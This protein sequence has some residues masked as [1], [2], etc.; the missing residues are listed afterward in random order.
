ERD[1]AVDAAERNTA[2]QLLN[3]IQHRRAS[4]GRN[5]RIFWPPRRILCPV[6]TQSFRRVSSIC[7][8]ANS[9]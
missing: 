4:S 5:R 8:G 9:A 6:A 1:Q 3:E 2:D 7:P